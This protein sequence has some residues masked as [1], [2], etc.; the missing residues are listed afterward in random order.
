MRWYG[1]IGYANSSTDEDGIT[2]EE[3]TEKEYCGDVYRSNHRWDNNNSVNGT[4]RTSSQISILS[5]P[6][7]IGNCQNIRYAEY[8]DNL[9]CV[10]DVEIQYP[11]LLLTLGGV[12]NG[13]QA[14]TAGVSGNSN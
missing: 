9:W 6:Y 2:T 4:V 10:V 7:I 14:E 3:I 1:K 8:M 12:Y 5:D 11:R 13:K